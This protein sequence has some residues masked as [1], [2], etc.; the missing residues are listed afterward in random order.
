ML[1]A[2]RPLGPRRPT[3][4]SHRQRPHRDRGPGP[5]GGCSRAPRRC[6]AWTARR[7]RSWTCTRCGTS[8]RVP[9]AA[10]GAGPRVRRRTRG[11]RSARPSKSRTGSATRS[12]SRNCSGAPRTPCGRPTPSRGRAGS[13][14]TPGGPTWTGAGRPRRRRLGRPAPVQ[15]GPPGVLSDP[16]R[17]LDGVGLPHGV[18]GA[19]LQFLEPLRVA[20][21]V[22]DLLGRALLVPRVL[23]RTR[24]P[25][26][27]A[28]RGTRNDVPQRVH[29]QE[30]RRRAVQ[31]R[32]RLGAREHP[33]GGPG[34]RSRCG[35]WR[36]DGSVGRRGPRGRGASSNPS[37]L[38]LVPGGSAATFLLPPLRGRWGPL[39]GG[40]FLL[41][42]AREGP[43]G[44]AAAAGSEV[45]VGVE[46]LNPRVFSGP[47]CAVWAREGRLSRS[48]TFPGDPGRYGS[49]ALILAAWLS[50]LQ[51]ERARPRGRYQL[52]RR[53]FRIALERRHAAR[54][55]DTGSV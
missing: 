12:G 38:W 45:M 23:R 40:H 16:A 37:P 51:C 47:F 34:P 20:E 50:P 11:T 18:L 10:R 27:R 53:P 22:R 43:A 32:H 24:G 41:P 42:A 21:P 15:V 54:V 46:F 3:E 48:A 44:G 1:L 19:P 2:P 39:C 17:P 9:R 36:W 6:R 4:P 28:A 29:V 8:F 5:P 49:G 31:A 33:P 14:R 35:R 7:R 13:L 30:R 52:F 55:T 25:A 26:P